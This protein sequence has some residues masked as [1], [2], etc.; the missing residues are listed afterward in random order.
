MSTSSEVNLNLSN[1]RISVDLEH[2]RHFTSLP[3][4]G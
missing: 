4:V 2:R 3:K 1:Y